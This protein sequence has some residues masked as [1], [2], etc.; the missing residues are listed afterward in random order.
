MDVPQD[1]ISLEFNFSK[2]YKKKLNFYSGRNFSEFR[3]YKGNNIKKTV[4][5]ILRPKHL[6]IHVN[7][8]LAKDTTQTEKKSCSNLVIQ[9][10]L[11]NSI[12]N[13]HVFHL[14]RK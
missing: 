13:K 6:S 12:F 1:K 3:G 11:G 10:I 5:K 9:Y 7:E 4:T 8:N 14:K 2:V